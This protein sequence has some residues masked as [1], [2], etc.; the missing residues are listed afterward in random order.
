[1][2]NKKFIYRT[3]LVVSLVSLIAVAFCFYRISEQ[4]HR[5]ETLE[6]QAR[7]AQNNFDM[8]IRAK[9]NNIRDSE[10]K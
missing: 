6:Q 9:L 5:I 8:M 1:M 3:S 10:D 4:M 2:S 7:F